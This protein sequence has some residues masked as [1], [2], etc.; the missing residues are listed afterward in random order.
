MTASARCARRRAPRVP[1]TRVRGSPASGAR[2]AAPATPL[3]ASG[4]RRAARSSSRRSTT[5]SMPARAST[6]VEA[7][8][9]PTSPAHD[10]A[11]TATTETGRRRACSA[12][13]RSTTACPRSEVT[14]QSLDPVD[15]RGAGTRVAR[16][17][18]TRPSTARRGGPRWTRRAS[19]RPAPDGAPALERHRDPTARG[20]HRER[21]RSANGAL[22]GRRPRP[23]GRSRRCG[24][25]QHEQLLARVILDLAR[26]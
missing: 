6:A 26:R 19:H 20:M 12:R 9:A 15:S 23:G 2:Q 7:S 24:I 25:E 3:A 21:A 18:P 1:R 17:H 4:A 8:S 22:E 11:S 5:T 14:T 16:R 13:R 10:A